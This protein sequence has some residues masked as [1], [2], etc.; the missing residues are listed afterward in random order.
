MVLQRCP[1]PNP[2]NVL[3]FCLIREKVEEFRDILKDPANGKV[4]FDYLQS[5]T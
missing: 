2:Q 1:H 4:I 3:I 5:L